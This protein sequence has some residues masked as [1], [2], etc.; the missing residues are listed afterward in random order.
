MDV[1]CV[2]SIEVAL[3][4]A[5]LDISPRM[6]TAAAAMITI[7]TMTSMSVNPAARRT[8]FMAAPLQGRW[9]NREKD[10]RPPLTS[11]CNG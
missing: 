2:I 8:R 7:A 3:R 6:V 11:L 4:V 1:A 10:K 5:M 9:A